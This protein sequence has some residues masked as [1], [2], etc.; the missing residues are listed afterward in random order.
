MEAV[1]PFKARRSV[2]AAGS[3]E[4]PEWREVVPAVQSSWVTTHLHIANQTQIDDVSQDSIRRNRYNRQR[5]N[6]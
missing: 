3:L 2:N 6:R 4:I 5:P 1:S